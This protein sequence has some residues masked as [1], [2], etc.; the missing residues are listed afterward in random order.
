[1]NTHIMLDIETLGTGSYSLVLSIGAV[2]FSLSGETFR[3]FSINLPILEQIINP[4]VEVDME[5]I[6]W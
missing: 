5:T 2:E 4:T 1:M 6:K 3:Q